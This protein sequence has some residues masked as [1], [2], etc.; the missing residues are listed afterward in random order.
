MGLSGEGQRGVRD[1][2][3]TRGRWAWN[4][5]LKFKE[6]LDNALRHRVGILHVPLCSQ[7]LDSTI[8]MGPFQ[9]RIFYDSVIF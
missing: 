5:L 3:C 2:V 9:I 1:R 8:L 6:Y 7:E 4:R